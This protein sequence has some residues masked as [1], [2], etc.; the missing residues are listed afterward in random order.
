[1]P[2]TCSFSVCE[3]NTLK[4]IHCGTFGALSRTCRSSLWISGHQI[5]FFSP[6]LPGAPSVWRRASTVVLSGDMCRA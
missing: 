5:S 2:H 4:R 1:M 6:D 3:L